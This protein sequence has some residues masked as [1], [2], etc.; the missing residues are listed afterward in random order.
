MR[1]RTEV[2]IEGRVTKYINPR[3]IEGVK[4]VTMDMEHLEFIYGASGVSAV[5]C[6]TDYEPA[7]DGTLRAFLTFD[8]DTPAEQE[9]LDAWAAQID[10]DD[11]PTM[12][13]KFGA[14]PVQQKDGVD[15][16][17]VAIGTLVVDDTVE[18]KQA[19]ITASEAL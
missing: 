3:Y 13:T 10:L 16:K 19:I 6:R 4:V 15:Y 11:V 9:I 17:P 14:A 5:T 1:I 18:A 7:E 2:P 8:A 12:L